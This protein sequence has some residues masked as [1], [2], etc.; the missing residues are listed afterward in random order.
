MKTVMKN[1]ILAVSAAAVLFTL[2][3]WA[4][5]GEL[6][7][8][9]PCD[10]SSWAVTDT[11]V[12]AGLPTGAH[13]VLVPTR[14]S[15]VLVPMSELT[16]RP[17]HPYTIVLKI[18]PQATN[19]KICLLNTRAT[20]DSDAMVYLDSSTRK[21]HIKQ[22]DKSRDSAVSEYG[23]ELNRWTA[24]A[25]AFGEEVTEIYI[26]GNPVYSGRATLAGSFADC[27]ICDALL[28]GAD[29]DGEDSP[30]YLADI[31]IYDG[32]RPAGDEL[33]GF[34]VDEEPFLI[35][36]AADWA[37]LASN[38]NRGITS[39]L[40][41]PLYRLTADIGTARAPVTQSIGEEGFPFEAEIDGS[42]HTLH[43]AISGSE[44]GT[45]P[46][47][48]TDKTYIHDL[49]VTGS[50][51]STANYAAGLVG[52][53]DGLTI[54]ENCIVSTAVSVSGATH[55]GGIIGHGGDN[56]ELKLLNSVFSGGISGFSAHAGGLIGWCGSLKSLQIRNV[57][58]KGS[59]NGSGRCHPIICRDGDSVVP[60]N[61]LAADIYYLNTVMST[62][63][64]ANIVSGAEGSPVNTT[65]VP[66][67]WGKA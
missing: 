16:D 62:E 8:R 19:G 63:D 47:V 44:T 13:A 9:D 33:E 15:K 40:N 45:A 48:R 7:A 29:N 51:S 14:G 21:V 58:F 20:K 66:Y 49:K 50:V 10:G 54:V 6:L 38:I 36:S 22:F 18:K 56:H 37:L 11:S 1:L 30:F 53:C 17:G 4:E 39:G 43:V 25:I 60:T 52:V 41:F 67:E 65:Y 32:A 28:I 5:Y 34:G 64:T 27:Y 61:F 24:I 59:F 55:A 57:L 26:D 12:L 46:F 2:P 3:V 42:S 23:I 31:R 35:T